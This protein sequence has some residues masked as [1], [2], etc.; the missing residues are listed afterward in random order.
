MTL[1]RQV[2]V[3]RDQIVDLLV[4][5][6]SQHRQPF[7]R[8]AFVARGPEYGSPDAHFHSFPLDL[9][10]FATG[11][12]ERGGFGD[13]VYCP[14]GAT[15]EDWDGT[16]GGLLRSIYAHCKKAKHPKPVFEP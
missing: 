11:A 6:G 10:D 15:I 2:P 8:R 12:S 16:A 14:C 1:R 3:W 7:L 5:A 9:D 13:E 4:P